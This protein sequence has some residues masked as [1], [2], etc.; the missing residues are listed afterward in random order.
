[1]VLT[2][3]ND[4]GVLDRE[5][6]PMESCLVMDNLSMM[7]TCN[8]TIGSFGFYSNTACSGDAEMDATMVADYILEAYGE[9]VVFEFHNCGHDACDWSYFNDLT[10]SVLGGFR[11]LQS[12]S[13]TADERKNS[14]SGKFKGLLSAGLVA[15]MTVAVCII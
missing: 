3:S 9:T 8:G 12:S 5:M 6:I 4:R 1:M 7:G 10:P 15:A 13:G 14:V 11:R 2:K